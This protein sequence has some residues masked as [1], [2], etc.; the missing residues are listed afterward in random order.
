MS[1]PALGAEPAAPTDDELLGSLLVTA[2]LLTEEACHKALACR[3]ERGQDL[4]RI[5]IDD[6]LVSETDLVAT[7]ARHLRLEFVDLN[8][9]PVDAAAARLV[10][11]S[12]AR[13]YLALPIGW[14][15]GRLIVAMADP[16]NVFAV[17]DIRTVTGAEIR[18][19]VATAGSVL[20]AIG[21]YHRV[22]SEA[23]DASAEAANSF[24]GD[25][26]LSRVRE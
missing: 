26:D 3:Q 9:Y 16:S 21:R 17:D 18:I 14:Y 4:A 22:D 12:M 23:E 8:E 7:L 11:D 25:V 13:R 20:D 5:L 6:N 19:A 10:S 1:A 24:E 2:G 15:E